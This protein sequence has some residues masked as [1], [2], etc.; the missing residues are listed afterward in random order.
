MNSFVLR[1]VMFGI[2]FGLYNGGS[3]RIACGAE[4][5]VNRA[6]ICWI[7]MIAVVISSTMH[8][9]DLKDVIGDRARNRRSA[10]LVLGDEMTRWT[11]VILIIAWSFICPLCLGVGL[12]AFFLLVAVGVHI[13]L[14]LLWCR[15]I[16]TDRRSWYAWAGWLICLYT[17]P[18]AK[19]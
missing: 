4:Q 12:L 11:L 5:S 6:G 2:A 7:L 9:Q 14:Q 17:L 18:L 19:A 10:P 15:D 1:N 8:I 3:L 16:C 13:S